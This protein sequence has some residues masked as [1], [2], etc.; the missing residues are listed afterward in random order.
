VRL[1]AG[2]KA[3]IPL[4]AMLAS[5]GVASGLGAGRLR[6]I[7]VVT[8][9]L[10]WLVLPPSMLVAASLVKPVYLDFLENFPDNGRSLDPGLTRQALHASKEDHTALPDLS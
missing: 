1:F 3:L 5:C 6:E 10:P 4:L 8:V 9:A 2:S 7:T